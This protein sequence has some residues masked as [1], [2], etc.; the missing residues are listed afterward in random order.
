[1]S[2]RS[3]SPGRCSH[4]ASL[5][6]TET[7]HTVLNHLPSF[8]SLP[9]FWRQPRRPLNTRAAALTWS[10]IPTLQLGLHSS[11][12]LPAL[13]PARPAG[14]PRPAA[15]P[16]AQLDLAL[17]RR[18]PDLLAAAVRPAGTRLTSHPAPATRKGARP[19]AVGTG[20]APSTSGGAATRQEPANQTK[21]PKT[22]TTRSVTSLGPPLNHRG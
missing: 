9:I 14:P 12:K 16:Q 11:C 7:G 20:A 19:G 18:F 3:R 1:M 13:Q 15:H 4:V 2:E 10:E 22:G 21:P 5:I 8:S 17:E 6:A